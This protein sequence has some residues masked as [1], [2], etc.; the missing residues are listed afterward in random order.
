MD[1]LQVQDELPQS[2]NNKPTPSPNERVGRPTK[3]Q[4]EGSHFRIPCRARSL[5]KHHNSETAYFDIPLHA[6]H[7]MQLACSLTECIQSGRRFR[8]C[9][10]KIGTLISHPGDDCK[11]MISNETRT[12]TYAFYS[13]QNTGCE[14][15]L[16]Q[17]TWSWIS[18]QC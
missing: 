7:G 17:T 4:C 8:Y 12:S 13:L 14:A 15:K 3:R 1:V 18:R 5:S 9:Q 6:P 10:G 16:C 11:K 2:L